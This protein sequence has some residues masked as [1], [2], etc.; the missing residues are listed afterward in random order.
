[1]E[2]LPCVAPAAYISRSK[3]VALDLTKKFMNP[4][5]P[6]STLRPKNRHF[7]S[8]TASIHVLSSQRFRSYCSCSSPLVILSAAAAAASD[9]QFEL[10]PPP[11]D[12]DFLDAAAAT[13]VITSDD[14]VIETFDNDEEALR[15]AEDGAVLV[16]LS[17]WGRIRVSGED[18]IQFLHN[19]ST[20]NFE[21]LREGQGCDTALVTPT[22]RAIDIAHAW[23]MKNAIILLVSPV[24]C[25]SIKEMLEKYIFFNDNVEIEDI[26]SVTSLFVLVGPKSDKVMEALDASDLVG[27]PYGT[28]QHFRVNG[29]PITVGVGNVISDTGYAMLMSTDAAEFVWK[30]VVSLDVLPMGSNAWERLRIYQGKPEP[31]KELT[32]EYNILEA[33]LWN[34]ISLNKGCYKGQ[35]T[36]SRLITYDGVKQN[37]WGLMLSVPA[38]PGSS[39]VVNGKKV[40]K[41]TSYAVGRNKSEHFG[42]GYIKRGAVS[43][44]DTVIIGDNSVGTLVDV[45]YLAR[46]SMPL[47]SQSQ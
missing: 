12:H 43:K 47:K 42:L 15:A 32:S 36:I 40:G 8:S 5:L 24:T 38:E 46:Q 28:H 26:S 22:A 39:I 20:A 18:R 29:M 31:G 14:G 13:G 41:L 19:Q 17:H 7:R 27:Q 45:P 4:S 25:K 9:S 30:T 21:C 2:G 23:I 10:S 16:D 3:T 11:I 1:M 37:L 35:E 34:S 44:G 33:G 6:S